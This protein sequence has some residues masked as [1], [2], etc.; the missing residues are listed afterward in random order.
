MLKVLNQLNGYRLFHRTWLYCILLC[1]ISLLPIISV[2]AAEVEGILSFHSDI[3][4]HQDA[5]MTVT[6]TIKVHAEG[7]RIKRGIYRDFPIVSHFGSNTYV[8]WIVSLF[9]YSLATSWN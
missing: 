2:H 6:E 7:D 1:S 5:S 8:L 3:V 9:S 4:V